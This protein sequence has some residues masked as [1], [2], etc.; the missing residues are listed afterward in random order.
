MRCP[1]QDPRYWTE[2]FVFEVP[3]PECGVP[4]E[5]F[6]DEARGRC[7]K[8]GHRFRNPGVDLRCAQWCPL[9]EKCLGFVPERQLADPDKRTALAGRLLQ[10]LKECFAGRPERL[11]L[12]LRSFY[13]AREL[14]AQEGGEPRVVLAAALLYELATEPT[15]PAAEPGQAPADQPSEQLVRSGDERIERLRH[16]LAQA[17]ADEETTARVLDVLNGCR[18]RKPGDAPRPAAEADECPAGHSEVQIV[19]DAVLLA[20][21]SL[22]LS[23]ACAEGGDSTEARAPSAA[24]QRTAEQAAAADQLVSGL[25][26][27]TAQQKAR[28]MAAG[29]GKQA[30]GRG[31]TGK[32]EA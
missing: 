5:F 6:K 1:G 25:S 10:E 21:L 4:V 2:D 24:E 20:R 14:V 17:G 23:A 22:E 3:C 19:A 11:A 31:S 28:A 18:P 13:F 30:G 32:P 7:P 16:L 26:T 9:A 12:V 15:K 8:C 29:V 27:A